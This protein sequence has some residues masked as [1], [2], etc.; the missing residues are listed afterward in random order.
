M[1]EVDLKLAVARCNTMDTPAPTCAVCGTTIVGNEAA[2]AVH[3]KFICGECLRLALETGP[4]PVL[5]Y[6]GRDARRR[7]WGWPAVAGAALIVVAAA[8]SLLV[9]AQRAAVARAR[10]EQMRA[11]AAE[12]RARAAAEAVAATLAA[13][14]PA[15]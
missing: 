8:V 15:D 3:D 5:A 2:H 12:Q 6:A 9:T 4:R 10:V 11:L 13:T 1:S 7:R 14:R